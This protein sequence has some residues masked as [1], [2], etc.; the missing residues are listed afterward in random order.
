MN[1]KPEVHDSREEQ[2]QEIDAIHQTITEM[3]AAFNK[4]DADK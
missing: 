3:E 2:Q 1:K 4:H